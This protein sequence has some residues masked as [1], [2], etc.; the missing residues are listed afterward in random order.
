MK[1]IDLYV[2]KVG[3]NLPEKIRADIEAEIRSS[4]EDTLEDRSARLGRSPDEAMV[5]E[6]LK[7]LGSPEKVAA[8]YQPPRYLV[9]P[10]LYPYFRLAALVYLGVVAAL[11]LAQLVMGLA[12]ASPSLEGYGNVLLRALATLV[13]GGLQG[14]G[15]LLVIFTIIQ[16]ALPSVSKKA[17]GQAGGWDPLSLRDEKKETR[18]TTAGTIVEVIFTFLALLLFNFYPQFIGILSFHEG[19]WRFV[20]VLSENFFRYLPW[21]NLVWVLLAAR[22]LLALRQTGGEKVIHWFSAAVSV[23]NIAMLLALA[24]GMP[25]QT[26]VEL[27]SGSM[28]AAG[29][30][31][32]TA[33]TLE[34]LTPLMNIGVLVLIWVLVVQEALRLAKTAFSL[35][36]KKLPLIKL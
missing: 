10:Q 13:T 35:L 19:Q 23:A 20:P 21:L 8:G 28:V 11:A 5:V 9:G 16:L 18:P 31:P 12:T 17:R 24:S 29:Y 32:Q 3:H 36:R 22:S 7:E 30:A 26:L 1:L 34:G 33:A 2:T 4:I 27:R 6:V 14:L 15:S 25:V